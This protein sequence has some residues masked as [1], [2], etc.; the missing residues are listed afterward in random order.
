MDEFGSV[1]GH[2][3]ELG[4]QAGA[5]CA[6]RAFRLSKI[7]EQQIA[8]ITGQ[9]AK[10]SLSRIYSHFHNILDTS[11]L[12]ADAVKS[13][14]SVLNARLFQGYVQGFCE[15]R[16]FIRS[17][18]CIGRPTIAWVYANPSLDETGNVLGLMETEL[19]R[20]ADVSD[21]DFNTLKDT[22]KC[23][24]ADMLFI[25][26]TYN[27]NAF[28]FH[29][30]G[31]ELSTHNAPTLDT[32]LNLTNP[33]DIYERLRR[34]KSLM[35]HAIKT[36][37]FQIASDTLGLEISPDLKDYFRGLLTHDKIAKKLFQG[38]GYVFSLYD[39]MK[40][41]VIAEKPFDR[42]RTGQGNIEFHVVAFTDQGRHF[43]HL[44]EDEWELLR[45]MG[46]IYKGIKSGRAQSSGEE[47]KLREREI[48]KTHDAILRKIR[49]NSSSG[50]RASLNALYDRAKK[51]FW[52]RGS[53]PEYL[54]YAFAEKIQGYCPTGTR[55]TS[56]QLESWLP[57]DL[58][59]HLQHADL[60]S[61][62]DAHAEIVKHLWKQEDT[63]IYVLSGTPG[64]GKT[65]AL[66]NILSE[67]DS[68]YLLV[69]ISPRIQVNTELMTKFDPVNDANPLSG[70]A[71][72]ICMST[73]AALIKAAECHRERPA[74]S[75]FAQHIP[76]DSKFLFLH[77]EDAES[78]ERKGMFAR[79]KT[80]YRALEK[81]GVGE[82]N[83]Y[84]GSGVFKT[85]MQAIYRLNVQHHY[86][87][88]IACVTTQSNKQLSKGITTVSAHLRKIFGS[89]REL[90]IKSVEKFAKNI[91]ELVFFIDEVTGDRA[92]RQTAQ[93]IIDFQKELKNAFSDVGKTCPLK[94]RMIIADAS[95][96]NAS[97]VKAFLSKTQ[98]QPDQILFNGNAD[99]KGLSVEDTKLMSLSAKI[100]NANVYPAS[101]LTLKWRPVLE[102]STTRPKGREK[103]P[104]SKAYRDMES[105][106]LETLAAE[107]VARWLQKPEEQVIVIIQNKESVD[108]L[109]SHILAYARENSSRRPDILTLHADSPPARKREIVSAAAEH[110]KK[111]KKRA[112][113]IWQKGDLDDIIIMTSSGTRGISFPNAS[114]IICVIPTFSLENNFME[115]LQGIYRG[116]GT[117][118]GN[119][120][121]REIEIII[122]QVLVSPAESSEAIEVSQISNLF[123]T[124]MIMRMSI[125]TRIF[126]AC[127]LFGRP[128]SCIPISGS[129]VSGA[130]QTITDSLDSAIRSLERAHKR[131]PGNTEIRYIIEHIRDIFKN[132]KVIL[133]QNLNHFDILLSTANRNR[134]LRQFT[135]DA[136][137]G[138]HI[139]ATGH[140]IP[141][142]CY[143]VGELL[144]QNLDNLGIREKTSIRL[145]P[146]WRRLIRKSE[147]FVQ[148]YGIW[149][150]IG[151]R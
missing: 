67:Y 93:E 128:I 50:L 19:S 64:I 80:G 103:D 120:L 105:R 125:L 54:N 59:E 98:A 112:A 73:N 39:T 76:E 53:L 1:Q 139:L 84:F 110:E 10:F 25:V 15:T 122:P 132:E 27:D 30:T 138:L 117:G 97:S 114:K 20:I 6:L 31:Y 94:F 70:K 56:A 143:T 124:Q 7:S 12:S 127:D 90:D 151:T 136:N 135:R 35:T 33:D 121:N 17:L 126:G 119:T 28:H 91:P 57:S 131:D 37:D 86:K 148:N 48:L 8:R 43:L 133:T 9:L 111:Q 38:G 118:K 81:G 106:I 11:F 147:R 24:Y 129:L 141:K 123:A 14:T 78:L 134:L 52:G 109:E 40:D 100:I 16:Q 26:K 79:K 82:V 75:C 104:V 42:W 45:E 55:P 89:T 87:R 88:I 46:V 107:L 140:Y 68:G 3:Y 61:M 5:I 142:G 130:S 29:L 85:M 66:R 108:A 13:A 99:S 49:K 95:L 58:A 62:Q 101:S 71:E 36:R 4:G 69:Y 63:D 92:G 47:R 60:K 74:V 72:M 44:K 144:L 23:P 77:P 21:V 146:I 18:P 41:R 150:R 115:F 145:K 137:T 51:T 2:T 96:I 65:T 102:F 34:G 83:H 116:R 22:G 113:G 32:E 149:L